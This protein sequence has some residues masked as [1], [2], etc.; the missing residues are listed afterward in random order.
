MFNASIKLTKQD[1]ENSNW[2]SFIDSDSEPECHTYMSIF[3]KKV[4]EIND[5]NDPIR[6]D[7]QTIVSGIHGDR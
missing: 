4:D 1:F 6:E 3:K 7:D 2:E 5:T